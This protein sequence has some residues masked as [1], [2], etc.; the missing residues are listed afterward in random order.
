M[1]PDDLS[2]T[3]RRGSHP[4]AAQLYVDAADLLEDVRHG[5]VNLHLVETQAGVALYEINLGTGGPP[6]GV[7][8][9]SGRCQLDGEEW[10]CR[11]ELNPATL[12]GTAQFER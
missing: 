3:F 9:F 12:T 10:Q 2:R 8:R 6:E 5:F 4:V 1:E 7:I 11:V